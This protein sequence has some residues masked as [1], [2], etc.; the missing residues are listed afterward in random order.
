MH[1]FDYDR[2]KNKVAPWHK[3]FKK[4]RRR[5]LI[6][7]HVLHPALRQSLNICKHYLNATTLAN[8]SGFR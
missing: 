8:C 7:L 5:I 2:R 1:D 6:N 4:N 3:E